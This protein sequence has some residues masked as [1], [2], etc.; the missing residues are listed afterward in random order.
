[1]ASKISRWSAAGL[2]LGALLFLAFGDR[3]ATA[4]T[5][6]LAVLVWGVGSVAGEEDREKRGG[7]SLW[8]VAPP[9][10]ARW[11]TTSPAWGFE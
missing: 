2:L 11:G 6:G 7:C 1:M 4:L 8:R 3:A 10:S 5:F 9:C